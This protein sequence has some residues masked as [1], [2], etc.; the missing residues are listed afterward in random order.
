MSQSIIDEVTF[1]LYSFLLGVIITFVYDGFL[2]LRRLIKHNIF[3]ISLE[4][5]IFWIACAISVFYV[6]Y[7]EN[8]GIL[9]WFAVAGAGLGMIAYKKTLSPLII[10]VIS[11]ALSWIFHIVFKTLCF[12]LKPFGFLMKKAGK[13][14]R[15]VKRRSG[16]IV[17]YIKKKLT[18][19]KKV[20]NIILCKH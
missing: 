19:Y 10:N 6:L 7:E 18:E 2:I 8:N 4:D 17:K 15:A 3:F 20:L 1:L 12:I 9:R 5:F 11:K 13:G 16:K 14:S